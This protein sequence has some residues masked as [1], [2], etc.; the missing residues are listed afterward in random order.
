MEKAKQSIK[1]CFEFAPQKCDWCYKAHITAGQIDKKSKRYSEAERNFLMAKTIVEDTDN[2]SGKYWVLLDLARL[3]RDNRQ[4]DKATNYYS[5]MFTIKDSLD[6][7]WIISNAMNIQTQAKVKVIEEEKK[8]LEFEKE[9]YAA[10]IK[11]QQ[12]QLF[13]LFCYC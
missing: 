7:Q 12:N 4:L 13:Y 1:K 6:N 2:L 11:N 8:R 9:L 10:K 3:A 5:E